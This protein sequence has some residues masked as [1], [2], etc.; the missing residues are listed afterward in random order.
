MKVRNDYICPIEVVT[1][2]LRGK[3]KTIILWRLR[4]GPTRLSALHKDIENI[5]EKVLIQQTSELIDCGFVSKETYSGY[6]LK[7][8]YSLTELGIELLSALEIIQDIGAKMTGQ[9]CTLKSK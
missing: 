5:A 4:L 7:V 2:M 8:E 1:D 3:W 9:T 6:P